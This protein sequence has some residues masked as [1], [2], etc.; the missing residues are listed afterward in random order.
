MFENEELRTV[1]CACNEMK[2]EYVTNMHKNMTSCLDTKDV[3]QLFQ[4]HEVEKENAL[5]NFRE[6]TRECSQENT[7]ECL[8]KLENVSFFYYYFTFD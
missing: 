6:M 7:E 5:S 8:N 2:A 3:A 4:Y 1:K